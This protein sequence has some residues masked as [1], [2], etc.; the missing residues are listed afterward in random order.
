MGFPFKMMHRIFCCRFL[1]LLPTEQSLA[2]WHQKIEEEKDSRGACMELM[3]TLEKLDSF[4]AMC[5]EVDVK[6]TDVVGQVQYGH[7]LVYYRANHHLL[8][9]RLR[10]ERCRPMVTMIQARGRGHIARKARNVL[11]ERKEA[12]SSALVEKRL[13]P[14]EKAVENAKRSVFCLSWKTSSISW[15]LNRIL[16]KEGDAEM[17]TDLRFVLAEHKTPLNN[18]VHWMHGRLRFEAETETKLR[19]LRDLQDFSTVE[20]SYSGDYTGTFKVLDDART[21]KQD[22]GRDTGGVNQ[23]LGFERLYT[24]LMLEN[25]YVE[26]S[27]MLEHEAV[28]GLGVFECAKQRVNELLQCKKGDD[29]L[30]QELQLHRAIRSTTKDEG[31]I[32]TWSHTD[33]SSTLL[34]EAQNV[35]RQ[36]VR[37]ADGS[38]LVSKRGRILLEQ[39]DVALILRRALSEASS[40]D[41]KE[42]F[43]FM[44]GRWQP[45]ADALNALQNETEVRKK[46]PLLSALDRQSATEWEEERQARE[47][48][49]DA[50]GAIETKVET[51]L[52]RNS[53]KRDDS[54]TG[55]VDVRAAVNGA[56][57][58]AW[59]PQKQIGAPWTAWDHSAI[60]TEELEK[61]A[62]QLRDFP[63]KRGTSLKLLEEVEV[64]LRTRILLMKCG[65]LARGASW[66]LPVAGARELHAHLKQHESMHRNNNNA[67]EEMQRVQ[68]EIS[69]GRTA[70]EA[71]VL[72]A[73]Q[74]GCSV[75]P[76]AGK[77]RGPRHWNH[78]GLDCSPLREALDELEA[79]CDFAG[80]SDFGSDLISQT[81]LVL[82]VREELKACNPLQPDSWKG[83]ADLLRG[84]KV[85]LIEVKR[86]QNEMDDAR[87][88]LADHVRQKIV[89]REKDR[90]QREA[91]AD[92]VFWSGEGLEW[93]DVEAAVKEMNRM[94]DAEKVPRLA[95]L[96]RHAQLLVELRK[97]LLATQN[98]RG[99]PDEWVMLLGILHTE[100]ARVLLG[101]VITPQQS[102]AESAAQAANRAALPRK[103]QPALLSTRPLPQPEQGPE[104][105]SPPPSPP[106]S[107]R[108]LSPPPSPPP[109]DEARI[110]EQQQRRNAQL[111]RQAEAMAL[112]EARDERLNEC[113]QVVERAEKEVK[114]LK[115][116]IMAAEDDDE[117]GDDEYEQLIAERK[118]AIRKVKDGKAALEQ[119][120]QRLM[121]AQQ[122]MDEPAVEVESLVA[123][124][125]PAAPAAPPPELTRKPSLIKTASMY[126]GS[127]LDGGN[128]E[129]DEEISPL[130]TIPAEAP[131][132]PTSVVDAPDAKVET[133]VKIEL[134]NARREVNHMREMWFE[135]SVK[136]YFDLE[137]WSSQ[138]LGN[139][140][141][142]HRKAKEGLPHLSNATKS[143]Q[144]LDEAE[145]CSSS[146]ELL[147]K[148]RA[149]IKV[150]EKLVSCSTTLQSV[151]DAAKWGGLGEVLS[152]EAVK[153]LVADEV[154]RLNSEMNDVKAL[155]ELKVTQMLE[156][157]GS[158]KKQ[159][160]EG[161]RA[162]WVRDHG[163][164]E[165]KLAELDISVKCLHHFPLALSRE[166]ERVIALGQL[167]LEL[168]R[169]LLRECNDDP[170][171]W[172]G[173]H[174]LLERSDTDL[175]HERPVR[176]AREEFDDKGRELVEH[177]T[178][179]LRGADQNGDE[180]LADAKWSLVD[181]KGSLQRARPYLLKLE[182]FPGQAG[183]TQEELTSWR[184]Q[185]ERA[186]KLYSALNALNVTTTLVDPKSPAKRAG[187]GLQEQL[188]QHNVE[189]LL[190]SQHKNPGVLE[191]RLLK[192]AKAVDELV[193]ALLK[194]DEK[195]DTAAQT[196]S[197]L[198]QWAD[199]DISQQQLE[200]VKV[201]DNIKKK[202]AQI[203]E[204]FK[205]ELKSSLKQNRSEANL[206]D[207]K[208]PWSHDKLEVGLRALKIAQDKLVGYPGGLPKEIEQLRDA[209][210]IAIKVRMRV[211][212]CDWKAT[213]EKEK[214]WRKH[215]AAWARLEEHLTEL[216]KQGVS[217]E[218]HPAQGDVLTAQK[219]LN[220][221]RDKIKERLNGILSLEVARV[222]GEWTNLKVLELVKAAEERLTEYPHANDADAGELL[223]Q[224][225][226]SKELIDAL[227]SSM[228]DESWKS[229]G[230]HSLTE[231]MNDMQQLGDDI[232]RQI[233]RS[234]LPELVER[235]SPVE[236]KPLVNQVAAKGKLLIALKDALLR[237]SDENTQP[238]IDFET[239]NRRKGG[240]ELKKYLDAVEGFLK[241]QADESRE[242]VE[243]ALKSGAA[244]IVGGQI[245]TDKLDHAALEEAVGLL[246]ASRY[247]G[248]SDE[249]FAKEA[250]VIITLRKDVLKPLDAKRDSS[251]QGASW[252]PLVE[253]LTDANGDKCI[254]INKQV[255]I[256]LGEA[257]GALM[258]VIKRQV[259]E[260]NNT[261]QAGGD[262]AARSVDVNQNCDDLRAL[263]ERLKTYPRSLQR[264]LQDKREK[265]ERDVQVCADTASSATSITPARQA[266][267]PTQPHIRAL[268][269]SV[270]PHHRRTLPRL[271]TSCRLCLNCMRSTGISMSTT[272]NGTA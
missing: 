38:P 163:M 263:F 121:D 245:D 16:G 96:T 122:T 95:T 46:Y 162:K 77:G 171:S 152:D 246:K 92:G 212:E 266:A 178:A 237:C 222:G 57:A 186:E 165:K 71:A 265:V 221:A 189:D 83:L 156:T 41:G 253:L 52:G 26:G 164:M 53:N 32:S 66:R 233:D 201:G 256:E 185:I 17:Q 209:A 25:D 34:S 181:A 149:T 172:R 249:I 229:H 60:K 120:Q 49:E 235:G 188:M 202:L 191:S 125:T 136:Q 130:A 224:T 252:T 145:P 216:V 37:L 42:P 64:S 247:L 75:N 58:A 61:A 31:D 119:L 55:R 102:K 19:G 137:A 268:P 105:P 110:V 169:A 244:E 115:R 218:G 39:A 88:L 234:G 159:V 225:K 98:A 116:R 141:W 13:G 9:E 199:R 262:D 161:A 62:R 23:A 7:T 160:G 271:F 59:F 193:Q 243:T 40:N 28:V 260:L 20:C 264:Q 117:M 27:K 251:K 204:P 205:D 101:E 206:Q 223:E 195:S 94:P 45:L 14:M 147:K 80:T 203:L 272:S 241:K 183:K 211:K 78:Q 190:A 139:Q 33:L 79:F 67:G 87:W 158:A 180:P 140:Q 148:A 231:A 81:H 134:S 207:V 100:G 258:E 50:C 63:S 153:Q 70:L 214:D 124:E 56:A 51:Q 74:I 175:K 99:A 123:D 44:N 29:K 111:A 240:E 157:G 198:S 200:L 129:G 150:R 194:C 90:T 267:H 132:S 118:A 269:L 196:F 257:E 113:E 1:F 219:E 104:P 168:R 4:K 109:E 142:D 146:T 135:Q 85:G 143:L 248:E 73:L 138:S 3:S 8:L 232:R 12:L 82:Q 184:A 86:S 220:A 154:K 255:K 166:G 167:T 242:R 238:L 155:C 47:E 106:S 11:L 259:S 261:L 133:L 108:L 177:L 197:R 103:H 213:D 68:K 254:F 72:K 170:A 144:L 5:E 114:K 228:N 131:L 84:A 174:D 24:L 91:N 230:A 192:M 239:Q 18:K 270:T 127:F 187:E 250:T 215:V 236:N 21:L 89:E 112:L 54:Y 6:M 36:E 210:G 107:P 69:D 227:A 176:D 43:P 93:E 173:L 128:K 217:K 48:L 179:Q 76:D 226:L 97:C 65:P 2:I 35:V 208:A 10:E 151:E 22:L 30:H 126:L 182:A 15:T